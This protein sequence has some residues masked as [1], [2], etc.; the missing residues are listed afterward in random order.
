M[1]S[2]LQIYNQTRERILKGE[3]RPGMRLP[4]HRELC[5]RFSVSI[6]TVTKAINRLKQ[7]GLVSSHRGLGTVVAE[8]VSATT[9]TASKMICLV[10]H[11]QNFQNEMLSRAVQEVFSGT[12]WMINARCTHSNLEWYKQYL[13]DCREHPPAG[14]IWWVVHPTIQPYTEEMLPASC[15]RV[16]QMV[17]E[18]PGRSYDLVRANSYANGEMVAEYLVS[19]GYGECVFVSNA[20]RS[21]LEV[22]PFLAGLSSGFAEQGVVFGMDQVRICDDAHCYVAKKDPCIDAY[23]FVSEMLKRERPRLIVTQHDWL[24]VAA[25]RAIQD[26]GLS[27]PGDIAVMSYEKTIGL[28]SIVANPK[29]TSVDTLVYYCAKLAAQILKRRLEGDER[30]LCCHEIHGRLCEGETT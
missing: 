19:K 18:V 22:S 12:Q 5:G 13:M 8:P 7:E 25:I 3:L 1:S 17:H 16:V 14:M 10:S 27:V 11:L 20:R 24:S 4:A 21:E 29:I 28:E 9:Q 6:A 26:A 15:T 23:N 2:Y 30:P